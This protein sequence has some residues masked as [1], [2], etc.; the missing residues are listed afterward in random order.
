MW[1]YNVSSCPLQFCYFLTV[2]SSVW[3]GG[4]MEVSEKL[5]KSGKRALRFSPVN[6]CSLHPGKFWLPF[7][8]GFC[9]VEVK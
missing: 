9:T 8:F 7:V 4:V 5:S 1:V 3:R 2:A 6:N